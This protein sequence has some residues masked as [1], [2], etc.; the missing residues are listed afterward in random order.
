LSDGVNW[1]FHLSLF[2]DFELLSV[3]DVVTQPYYGSF[4]PESQDR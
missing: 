2:S 1:C 3:R 4:Y